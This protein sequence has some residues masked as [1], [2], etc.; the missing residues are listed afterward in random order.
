MSL[1]WGGLWHRVVPNES[2]VVRKNLFYEFAP[3]W[4]VS[5]DRHG[6]NPDW[7]SGLS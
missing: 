4:I 2:S 5:G 1:M 6:S 7:L 3:G